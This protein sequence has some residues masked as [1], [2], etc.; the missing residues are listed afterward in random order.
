MMEYSRNIILV[1]IAVFLLGR[2]MH[3]AFNQK[4]D[5]TMSKNNTV[6]CNKATLAEKNIDFKIDKQI[7]STLHIDNLDLL[8]A[9]SNKSSYTEIKSD[10]YSNHALYIMDCNLSL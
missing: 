3:C 1:F 6:Q 5:N 2:F 9:S 10:N 7:V 8:N 4:V